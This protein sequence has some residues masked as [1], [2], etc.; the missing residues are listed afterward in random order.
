[1]KT[2]FAA[3]DEGV[4]CDECRWVAAVVEVGTSCEAGRYVDVEC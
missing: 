2:E 4:D 3:V 1:M